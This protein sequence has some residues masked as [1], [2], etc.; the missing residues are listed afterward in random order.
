MKKDFDQWNRKKKLLH[1]QGEEPFY[2]EREIWWC[3]LGVNVGFEQDGTGSNFDRPIL[4]VRGF[5]R[6][7]CFCV[8]LTGKKKEGKY[9]FYLGEIDGRDASAILS[10]VR[11]VDTKRLVKKIGML[12][13]Q[14]FVLLKVKMGVVLFGTENS[15]PPLARGRGRSHL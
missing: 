12:D 8:A 1:K 7:T 13:E 15:L 4:I 14:S 2:H 3:A 5:N 10:Q 6:Q 11:L 9:Y